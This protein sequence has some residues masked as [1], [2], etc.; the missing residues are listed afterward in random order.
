G[1]LPVELEGVVRAMGFSGLARPPAGPFAGP[2]WE[3]PRLPSHPRP[4]RTGRPLRSAASASFTYRLVVARAVFLFLV[5][6]I[7]SSPVDWSAK[8]TTPIV[9]SPPPTRAMV[10]G[11]AC[12][13][14][15]IA[16]AMRRLGARARPS[17]I[18]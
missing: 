5:S 14:R 7:G 10:A 1:G 12:K 2:L 15:G 11:I 9:T 4:H 17:A 18:P 8:D 3:S 16:V 13:A 6:H